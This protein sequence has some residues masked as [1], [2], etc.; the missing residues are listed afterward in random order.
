VRIDHASVETGQPVRGA[1]GL[2]RSDPGGSGCCRGVRVLG[3]DEV[4][5]CLVPVSAVPDGHRRGGT[6]AGGTED[7]PGESRSGWEDSE[8][9]VIASWPSPDPG[10]TLAFS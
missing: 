7:Y 10:H 4:P 3:A 1:T 9:D 8:A 2:F 6:G 5:E